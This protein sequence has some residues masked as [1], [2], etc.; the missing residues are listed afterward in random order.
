VQRGGYPVS[1]PLRA[2]LVDRVRPVEWLRY[3]CCVKRSACVLVTLIA[4]A[5]ASTGATASASGIRGTVVRSPIT[6]VCR[7]GVRCSAPAPGVVVVALRGGVRVASATTSSAG[8]YRLA[9]PPGTY[10]LRA[11][12]LLM[13]GGHQSRTVRVV[14][15]VFTVMNFSVDTGIR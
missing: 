2:L 10:V 8:M 9:L 11:P 3:S 12:R 13:S 5:S 4:L 1:A 15:G 7:E 14:K 6:P